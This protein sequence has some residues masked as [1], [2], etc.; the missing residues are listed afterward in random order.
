[1]LYTTYVKNSSFSRYANVLFSHI[2][3]AGALSL[4]RIET[5]RCELASLAIRGEILEVMVALMTVEVEE[6]IEGMA[7]FLTRFLRVTYKFGEQ[8]I[9][10]V[11]VAV[12]YPVNI[13]AHFT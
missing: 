1:M 11:F 13:L 9:V 2:T 12:D 3:G 10:N 5:L 8:K 7:A 6:S 4:S